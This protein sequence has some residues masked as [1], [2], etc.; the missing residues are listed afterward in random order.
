MKKSHQGKKNK[1][2]KVS[3]EKKEP[4]YKCMYVFQISEQK[5]MCSVTKRLCI[6]DLA[7][8]LA[9]FCCSVESFSLRRA[10][11]AIQRGSDELSQ[12]LCCLKSRY[13]LKKTQ[14]VEKWVSAAFCAF[15]QLPGSFVQRQL[16]LLRMAWW[17]PSL[18]TDPAWEKRSRG[19]KRRGA[20]GWGG[21]E[22]YCACI[23]TTFPS[24]GCDNAFNPSLSILIL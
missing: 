23:A 16:L 9:A 12:A 14:T 7:A 11:I 13:R 4:I 1:K 5:E 24:N 2:P 20:A 19:K 22:V 8:T 17:L 10:S 18:H 15:F 3:S 21:R 6:V